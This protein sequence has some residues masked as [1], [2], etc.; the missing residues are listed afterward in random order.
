MGI[1]VI[2]KEKLRE[3]I[4]QSVREALKEQSKMNFVPG[5][6]TILTR[7]QLRERL[8]ISDSTLQSYLKAGMPVLQ[9]GRK[10]F[11]RLEDVYKW[12]EKR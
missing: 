3:M 4:G 6:N 8:H 11:F 10:Q 12:M 5:S 2:S 9:R 7:I 1:L